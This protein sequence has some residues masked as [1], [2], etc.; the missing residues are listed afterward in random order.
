MKVFGKKINIMER[1][2]KCGQMGLIIKVTM[3]TESN[4]GSVNLYGLMVA[5]MMESG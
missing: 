1:A 3:R 4:K 5:Y 2:E